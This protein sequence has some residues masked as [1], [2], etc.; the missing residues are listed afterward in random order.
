MIDVTCPECGNQYQVSNELAGRSV[1]CPQC[2]ARLRVAAITA[3]KPLPPP[4]SE[5]IPEAEEAP[6]FRCEWIY[7]MVQLP[8][9]IAVSSSKELGT[10]GA[11]FLQ[12]EVNHYARKGWEFYRVDAIGV[13]VQPSFTD[14]FFMRDKEKHSVFY[15]ITF[16]KRRTN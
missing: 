13:S 10:A 4:A 2:E 15:V 12:D 9:R 1:N 11:K 8:P 3:R 5:E 7:K 14:E 6:E 16:R